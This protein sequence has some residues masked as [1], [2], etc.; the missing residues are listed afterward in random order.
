MCVC[1]FYKERGEGG[2]AEGKIW[3]GGGQGGFLQSQHFDYV[4]PH[5][6]SDSIHLSMSLR[7]S[8]HWHVDAEKS[9]AATL[10]KQ[11]LKVK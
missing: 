4:G 7:R 3:G 10:N 9:F 6:R 1:V 11:P 8:G 5:T 2:R